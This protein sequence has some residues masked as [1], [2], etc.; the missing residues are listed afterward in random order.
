M[1]IRNVATFDTGFPHHVEAT[2]RWLPP[3]SRSPLFL[4]TICFRSFLGLLLVAT[5]GGCSTSGTQRQPQGLSAW[6]EP[7]SEGQS[8]LFFHAQRRDQL[9]NH[10]AV[11][12]DDQKVFTLRSDAYSWCYVKPGF[13]TVKAEWEPYRPELNLERRFLFTPG[14]TIYL[15]LVVTMS[16][17]A[18]T[19]RLTTAEMPTMDSVMAKLGA[20]R[21]TYTPPTVMKVGL[22]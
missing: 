18:S 13:H 11:Y 16:G 15:R 8:L 9:P 4:K 22:P 10:P 14:A 5:L 3:T 6:P 21:S 20:E 12:V 2:K 7:P 19:G 17:K 1:S